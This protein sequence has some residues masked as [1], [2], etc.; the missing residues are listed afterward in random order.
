MKDLYGKCGNNCG[1]CA[2]HVENLRDNRRQWCVEGLAKYLNWNPKPESLRPCTGC[3]SSDGFL[4]LRNC[5]VRACARHNGVETCAQCTVFPCQDVPTVS[6]PADYRDKL[7]ERLGHPIPEEDYLSFVEPYEGMAHLEAIRTGLR[8][9]QLVPPAPVDPLKARIV[10]F[11]GDLSRNGEQ[12]AGFEM[13]HRLMARILGGRSELYVRQVL[14]RKRRH[15]ILNI[16]WAFG[17]YGQIREMNG[18]Q[19]I[20]NSADHDEPGVLANIVRKCDNALHGGAALSA[21]LL[22]DFGLAMQHTALNKRDWRLTLSLEEE[23][24]GREAMKA[25]RCYTASLVAQYGEPVYRGGSRFKGDAYSRFSQA[26]MRGLQVAQG[27]EVVR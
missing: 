10:A 6:H 26:D 11:P 16:L 17:R 8:R 27:L 12:T 18:D 24:G 19:L 9:S 21:R 3:Q 13:L 25:L 7:S 1:H 4:Y 20:I 23:A 15:T 22:A 5:A 2:L 14:L